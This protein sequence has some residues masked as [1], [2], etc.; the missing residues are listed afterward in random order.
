MVSSIPGTLELEPL[1]GEARDLESWVSMFHLAAVVVD[2]FTYESSW[3]LDTAIRVL[4]G[5]EPADCRTAFVVTASAEEAATFMGPLAERF[6]VL[7]DPDRE[8]VDALG[9]ESLPAFTV[10]ST[11]LTV[12][13]LAEGWDPP[14]WKSTA[15]RLSELLDWTEPL[16]PG[17]GDPAP[18]A[19]TPALG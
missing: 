3:I 19:G 14:E 10:I 6:L 13:G 11:S 15:G 2:P 12:E 17:P 9:A 5:Y 7:A 8:F 16:I 1:G 18:Y 4:E